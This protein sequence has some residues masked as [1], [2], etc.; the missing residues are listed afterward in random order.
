MKPIED[1]TKKELVAELKKRNLSASGMKNVLKERLLNAIDQQ[2]STR[3]DNLLND[4]ETNTLESI[5]QQIREKQRVS[6]NDYNNGVGTITT[7]NIGNT[8]FISPLES[9]SKCIAAQFGSLKLWPGRKRF[10]AQ[11]NTFR[12]RSTNGCITSRFSANRD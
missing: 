11:F 7:T 2:L 6:W 12:S 3:L 4:G 5:D 1:M 10:A 9:V 8:S